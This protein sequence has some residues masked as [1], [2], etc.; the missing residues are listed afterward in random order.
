MTADETALSYIDRH[1]KR[2]VDVA[3]AIWNNPEVALLEFFA[4]KLVAGEL[5][6]AGFTVNRGVGQM[7]TAF[8]ASW[9]SGEPIIGILGEYDALPGLS[10]AVSAAREPVKEGAPGHGCGHNLFAAG[11]LGAAL[12]VKDAMEKHHLSGTIRFY[13]CPGG[14][15]TDWQG[16]HGKRRHVRRSERRSGLA[17][18]LHQQRGRSWL[19]AGDEFLPGELLR[20]SRARV[21]CASHGQERLG[22]SDA[23]G[24]WRQLSARACRARG[25]HP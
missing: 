19:L 11:S 16:V 25:P 20:C 23:D 9:G 4:A 13:G 2:L 1:E 5:E 8:V 10:Q 24:Y 22:W 17:P 12:A 7:P 3:Q 15:N 6:Q 21:R 14:R 18:G